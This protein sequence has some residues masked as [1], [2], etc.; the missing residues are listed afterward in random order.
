MPAISFSPTSDLLWPLASFSAEAAI[1]HNKSQPIT[2]I[3]ASTSRWLIQGAQMSLPRSY[4]QAHTAPPTAMASDNGSA[5]VQNLP[6]KYTYSTM[7]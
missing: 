1:G 2:K 7:T 5:A 6:G 4:I 3:P